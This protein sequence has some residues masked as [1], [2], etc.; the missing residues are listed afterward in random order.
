MKVQILFAFGESKDSQKTQ[1]M[2]LSFRAFI[3]SHLLLSF[4]CTPV[5]RLQSVC[6]IQEQSGTMCTDKIPVFSPEEICD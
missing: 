6:F 1:K 4:L 5:Y 2:F 3:A